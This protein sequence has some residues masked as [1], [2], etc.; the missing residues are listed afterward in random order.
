[1]TEI[2]HRSGEAIV[3]GAAII[4][5]TASRADRIVGYLRQPIAFQPEVGMKVEVRSRSLVQCVSQ[6]EILDVGSQ[7]EPI[8]AALLASN[9]SQIPEVGLPV[10][11]SIPPSQKLRPGELVDLR[12]LGLPAPPM[13]RIS[14]L[15]QVR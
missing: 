3:A 14:D 4:T 10:L 6:A 8:S 7:M 13:P 2:H 9:N 1:V 5:I 11:V 12:I 15:I